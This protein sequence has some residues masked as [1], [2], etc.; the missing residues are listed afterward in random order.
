[1]KHI[2]LHLIRSNARSTMFSACDVTFS[3]SQE[4]RGYGWM[5]ISSEGH[6]FNGEGS[7]QLNSEL[8][9]SVRKLLHV[10]VPGAKLRN[11]YF[12][13]PPL[14][15]RRRLSDPCMVYKLVDPPESR[16]SLGFSLQRVHVLEVE[17]GDC[18]TTVVE[19]SSESIP[20][21]LELVWPI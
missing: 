5:A 12:E 2:P 10:R 7:K 19:L 14:E 16:I 9:G 3:S 21:R 13:S 15:F 8:N 18:S 20:L 1:M 6:I 11:A 4:A 17:E